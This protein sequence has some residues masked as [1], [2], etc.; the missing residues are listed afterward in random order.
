[1]TVRTE[2]SKQQTHEQQPRM[3]ESK[4]LLIITFEFIDSLVNLAILVSNQIKST[5]GTIKQ[6][7]L[8]L[9]ILFPLVLLCGDWFIPAQLI[10]YC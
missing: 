9:S 8:T 3:H 4:C 10:A 2:N 6:L 7:M 5:T 1:M